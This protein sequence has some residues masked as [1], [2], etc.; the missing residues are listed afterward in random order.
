MMKFYS[1]GIYAGEDTLN[2]ALDTTANNI[3]NALEPRNYE[4]VIDSP[5]KPGV[6]NYSK[7]FD[8]IA[9]LL[10]GASGDGEKGQIIIPVYL[11]NTLLDTIVVDA[12]DRY[13]YATGGH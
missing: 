13:N 5:A 1:A 2:D 10:S 3:V 9:D 11:G 4:D 6:I 12:I 8:R 7:N